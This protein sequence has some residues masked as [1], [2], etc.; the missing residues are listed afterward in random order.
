MLR[1]K[2]DMKK[3]K[4]LLGKILSI[5]LEVEDT[6]I[7]E[8]HMIPILFYVL[9]TTYIIHGESSTLHVSKT[10]LLNNI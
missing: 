2:P 9:C 8:I 1:N 3:V 7:A 6:Y 10:S 4:R 5:L